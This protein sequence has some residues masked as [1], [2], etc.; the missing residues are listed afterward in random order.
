MEATQ[1]SPAE[2]QKP[3]GTQQ[4]FYWFP[5]RILDFADIFRV[6]L[7][8]GPGWGGEIAVTDK[9][10]L[11]SYKVNQ[12]GF[13]WYGSAGERKI[14]SHS[15]KYESKVRGG[16]ATRA[17]TPKDSTR[18]FF[19]GRSDE[20]SYD[21]R[22]Q[23]ALGLVQ[24]YL[25]VDFYE[26]GDFFTGLTL[27]DLRKDDMSPMAFVDADPPRKLGRGVSN[28]VTGITEIPRTIISVDKGYGG[29]AAYTWGA[30][31]GLKRFFVR[32]TVGLYEILTFPAAGDTIIEPEYPFIPQQSDTS[33]RLRRSW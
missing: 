5:N 27:V 24:P 33:W 14:V 1:C 26:I 29:V 28:L 22:G 10:Q 21:V 32:E 18:R 4:F 11:G 19:R 7:A 13:G 2:Q 6:G 9:Y 23:F 8:F 31:L 12:T 16:S 30:A 25:G 3:T 15:G 20:Q 17:E